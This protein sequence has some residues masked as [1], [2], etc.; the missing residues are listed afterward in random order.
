MTVIG[1]KGSRHP[2]PSSSAVATSFLT[3]RLWVMVISWWSL[4][5]VVWDTFQGSPCLAQTLTLGALPSVWLTIRK[6]VICHLPFPC[7]ALWGG[8]GANACVRNRVPALPSLC[9]SLSCHSLYP[10]WLER[11]VRESGATMISLSHFS[12]IRLTALGCLIVISA[13]L[14]YFTFIDKHGIFESSDNYNGTPPD[15]KPESPIRTM[16]KK[17]VCTL[18][19][20]IKNYGVFV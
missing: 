7:R 9:P 17:S 15:L 19:W 16:L 4:C 14:F 3:G 11:E 8:W 1:L 13:H 10:V 5:H 6:K 18:I 20:H 2:C 12:S